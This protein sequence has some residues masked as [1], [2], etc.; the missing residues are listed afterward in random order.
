MQLLIP[1]FSTPFV[2]G[3]LL[4][5]PFLSAADEKTEP[6]VPVRTVS[7]EIPDSFSRSGKLGLVTINLRVDDKG[8]V[9][10]PTVV[11]SSHSELEEPAVNAIR[12][13]RFK[14]ARRDGSAVSVNVTIP[15]RFETD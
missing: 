2:L 3:L 11:K 4:V 12:K 6:P 7:P 8:N 10:D 14:P 9:Q 13:W 15:I 1:K 5:S